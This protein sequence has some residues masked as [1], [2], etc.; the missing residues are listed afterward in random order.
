MQQALPDGIYKGLQRAA[1]L[2][3]AHR[4]YLQAQSSRAAERSALDDQVIEILRTDVVQSGPLAGLVLS[5]RASWGL[6]FS[7][8]LLGTYEME[9]HPF[10]SRL[11][12][13][14]TPLILD[15]GCADGY[16]VVGLS[17][18]APNATV[19]GYDI[20][21]SALEVTQTLAE[22]NGVEG[23][24][25]V[26]P[27]CRAKDLES[28]PD[29]TLVVMDCEGAESQL[30]TEA[31]VATN[32]RTHFIIE[33]HESVVPGITAKL[34]SLF[35]SRRCELVYP[36]KRSAADA[37]QLPADLATAVLDEMR[38][39]KNPWLVVT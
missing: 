12:T 19:V 26:R 33:S 6:D 35:S 7:A 2:R 18:I 30:L 16:Y 25:D 20:D 24:V 29:G 32:P 38:S 23:R 9:L 21:P 27:G 13:D 34:Q 3:P 8:R 39:P 22:L 15:V 17:R 11:V 10:L 36:D 4:R 28:L 14:E 5:R 1:H 37:T 31:V